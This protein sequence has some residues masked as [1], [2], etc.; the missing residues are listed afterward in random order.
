MAA[1]HKGAGKRKADK[2]QPRKAKPHKQPAAGGADELLTMD[3]AIAL[4]KTTRSTFHRWLRAGKVEGMKVGRQWRFQ[5][6]EIMRFLR[7]DQRRVQL[8]ADIGPLIE[9]LHDRLREVAGHDCGLEDAEP[10]DK[11][12]RLVIHL[13]VRMRASDIHVEGWEDGAVIRFRVDGVLQQIARFDRRLLQPVVDRWKALAECDVHERS[14][15]QDGRIGLKISAEDMPEEEVDLRACFVPA[16]MGEAVTLRMLRK[17]QVVLDLERLGYS[18]QDLERI[19]Q[20]LRARW[21]LILV[22]GPTGTGKTTTLYSCLRKLASPELKI[23]SIEDPVEYV[24]PGVVQVP[25]RGEL[26]V[27]FSRLLRALLRSAPDVILVGEIRDPGTLQVCFQASLTGHLVLTTLHTDSAVGALRRMVDMGAEPFLV[28]DATRLIV[29]QRII[30]VLCPVCSAPAEVD[31]TTLARAREAARGS[32]LDWAAAPRGF[33][34]AVGCAECAQSGYRGRIAVAETLRVTSEIGRALRSGAGDDELTAIAVG[35]GM[36]TMV[37]DAI[38]KAGEGRT[39]LE[40]ALRV[41]GR[42]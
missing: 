10:V 17:D 33:R 14:K 9:R 40:E 36:T 11:V 25:L 39:T 2:S 4:L 8:T 7:G 18:E 41:L 23:M 1:K 21:G 37:A 19:V 26:G 15:P 38:R 20:G 3:Q 12:I 27:G 32:G 34:K 5:R 29:A 35:Q 13:A 30:R 22:A 24:L 16:H 31:E 6:S 28:A 42:R